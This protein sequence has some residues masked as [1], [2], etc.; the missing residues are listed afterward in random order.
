[1][2][3]IIFVTKTVEGNPVEIALRETHQGIMVSGFG[4]IENVTTD[5]SI[6]KADAI[7]IPSSDSFA[8]FPPIE[9]SFARHNIF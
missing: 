2:T 6:S 3:V 7:F 8:N 5:S 1:M 4:L 9:N